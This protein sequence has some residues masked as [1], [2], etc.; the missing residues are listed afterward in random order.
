MKSFVRHL[1]MFVSLTVIMFP[2]RLAAQLNQGGIPSSFSLSMAPDESGFVTISPPATDRLLLEDE[3]SPLPYRFAVNLP[4][5]LD[6]KSTGHWEK[7]VDGTNI[8]RLSLSSPGALALTLYF[9]RFDLPKGGKLFVYN[10]RRT[11][12]IGAFTSLNNSSLQTFATGLIYG[13]QLT[14]EYDA[15]DG[16]PVP[17]IHISEVAHAYKGV[18]DHS[19]LITFLRAAGQCQVNF[20]CFEGGQ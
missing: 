6:I 9:D 8:W 3:Q 1:L 13:D 11:Q 17:L 16:L 4:V 12:C 19:S 10:P 15:P 14:L 5:D 18:A 2:G 20:I 7:T